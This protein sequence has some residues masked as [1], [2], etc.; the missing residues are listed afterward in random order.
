MVDL[1]LGRRPRWT[2][3]HRLPSRSLWVALVLG[4]TLLAGLAGGARLYLDSRAGL[5]QHRCGRT[6][7]VEYAPPST[8]ETPSGSAT[9]LA[10]DVVW[11]ASGGGELG[12][13][14]YRG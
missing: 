10:P 3:P 6:A 1:D 12:A 11:A 4:V 7:C 8:L 14:P 5:M 9:V 13:G 2:R